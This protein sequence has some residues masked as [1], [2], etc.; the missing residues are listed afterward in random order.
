MV[1]ILVVGF[2]FLVWLPET[3]YAKQSQ[4]KPVP[5]KA[6][7][8]FV[9]LA[10][11][12]EDWSVPV[13]PLAGTCSYY[14]FQDRLS[15]LTVQYK[16]TKNSSWKFWTFPKGSKSLPPGHALRFRTVRYNGTV[17]FEDRNP[18]DCGRQDPGYERGLK[19]TVELRI[20]RNTWTDQIEVKNGTCFRWWTESENAVYR[21]QRKTR[22]YGDWTELTPTDGY[23]TPG[24]I[25][26]GAGTNGA[27]I[28][29]EYR[30]VGQCRT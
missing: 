1:G 26:F 21:V 5:L 22:K 11:S 15:N 8:E 16:Q 27:V 17:Y 24:Y 7:R 2:L 28:H 9:H 18:G 12:S 14:E 13:Y 4:V 25:R 19:I 6:S 30:P 29:Y 20:T 23:I 3:E 10:L